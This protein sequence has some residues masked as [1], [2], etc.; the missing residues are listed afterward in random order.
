MSVLLDRSITPTD[1]KLLRFFA[2][3]LPLMV[4]VGIAALVLNVGIVALGIVAAFIVLPWFINDPFR[5]YLFLL[6]TWPVLNLYIQVTLPAGM[7]DLNYERVLVL[8]AVVLVLIPALAFKRKVPRLGLWV[9]L[10]IGG[11]AIS[12]A[13]TLLWGGHVSPDLVILLNSFLIPMA[14]YWLTKVVI[15][16]RRRIVQLFYALIIASVMISLSGIYEQ[17]FNLQESPFPLATGTA[18]GE[19]YLDV[20]GGRAAGVIGNP[21]IYG[22]LVTVGLLTSICCFHES[23]RKSHKSLLAASIL[24]LSYSVVVSY[25]RSAWIASILSLI[26]AQ[27]FIK[28]L[29][30]WLLQLFLVG[31]FAAAFYLLVVG[32][33]D[34]LNSPIFQDRILN[35][36]NLTG[37]VDRG[38]FAWDLVL[39]RPIFGWG[40]GSLNYYTG[41]QFPQGGFDSSHNTYLTMLVDGG[42][43]LFGAFIVLVAF[44]L[45][46]AW[47]VWQLS[48]PWT[49]ERNVLGAMLGIMLLFLISGL[50]LELKYFGYFS[51]LFWIAGAILERL[52]DLLNDERQRACD[53]GEVDVRMTTGEAVYKPI[54]LLQATSVVMVATLAA[55][56]FG[57]V[58]EGLVAAYFGTT[59][60]SDAYFFAFDLAASL[61]EFLLS[62]I[63]ACLIPLYAR[64]K[65]EGFAGGFVSTIINVYTLVLLLVVVLMIGSASY[66]VPLLA[67]GFSLEGQQLI[68]TMLRMLPLLSC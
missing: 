53:G 31:I 50:A 22:V 20:P 41:K 45:L 29:A 47:S 49:L 28:S 21:A 18:S 60:T 37:R 11:Q 8:M 9:M 3:A 59:V 6:A 36:Q 34:F 51:A 63:G 40:A 54:G 35:E 38:I 16:S 15:T 52:R 25:T 39:E 2:I 19:R 23:K 26:V 44:W 65:K 58:R 57:L 27:F 24:L 66:L 7:P 17:V 5:I 56:L 46:Q 61:P 4:G 48:L 64:S 12:Y 55:S 62:A 33:T 32:D 43:L 42:L 13:M 68:A 1:T 14:L 10:Y 30:K 67:S